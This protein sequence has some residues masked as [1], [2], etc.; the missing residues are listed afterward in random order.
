MARFIMA[1]RARGLRDTRIMA[2]FERTPRQ[3]F[4]GTEV[5][6]HIYA[7][8]A[9]PLPCGEQATSAHLIAQIINA[10]SLAPSLRVLEI[11]T[12][13]GYQTALLAKIVKTVVSIERY[14]SLA[15]IARKNVLRQG[16][17]TVELRFG[18]GLRDEDLPEG[19]FDR[20]IVN[21]SLAS[22][23]ESLTRRLSPDGLVIAPIE[24]DGGQMLMRIEMSGASITHASIAASAFAPIRSGCA[25]SL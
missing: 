23:P 17:E 11:G 13:S 15:E 10:A 9:L 6:P 12:G 2:A 16:L 18:D 21:G 24:T 22:L 5:W 19:T 4:F 8:I 20:I 1:L 14:H 25:A 3:D 7:D